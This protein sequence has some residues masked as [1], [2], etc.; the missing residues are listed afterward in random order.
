MPAVVGNEPS[1]AADRLCC[2]RSSRPA[3]DQLG[4][5]GH[6]AVVAELAEGDPQPAAIADLHNGV[7][8]EVAQFADSHARC[9][10]TVR[11]TS[12]RSRVGSRRRAAAMTLAASR[13][14][15]NLGSGSGLGWGGR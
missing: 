14:S 10:L 1:V 15:K 8:V 3:G 9:G 11:R 13:S 7:G 2:G 5:K 4:E 12:R 6:V